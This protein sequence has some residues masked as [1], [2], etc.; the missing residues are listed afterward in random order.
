MSR[1]RILLNYTIIVILTASKVKRA[2]LK[3][4]EDDL[5]RVRSS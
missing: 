3:R 1:V 2:S 4:R 5:T